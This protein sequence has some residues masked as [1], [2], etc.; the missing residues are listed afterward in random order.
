MCDIGVYVRHHI[1]PECDVHPSTPISC[2]HENSTSPP[3]VLIFSLR[4]CVCVGGGGGGARVGSLGMR[5]VKRL[6]L[7]KQVLH[8]ESVQSE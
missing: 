8:V 2:A 3:S 5:L 1:V 4:V 7:W 6:L